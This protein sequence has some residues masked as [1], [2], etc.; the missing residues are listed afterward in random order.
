M[1]AAKHTAILGMRD[2]GKTYRYTRHA[3]QRQS[4]PLYTARMTAA[5]QAAIRQVRQL[6]DKHDKYVNRNRHDFMF[7]NDAV[8]TYIAGLT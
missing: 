7:F 1:T 5:E 6:F 4:I 3:W 2:S 8:A